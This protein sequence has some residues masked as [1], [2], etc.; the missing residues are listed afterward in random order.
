MSGCR[1]FILIL[2]LTLFL[3]FSAHAQQRADNVE[4]RTQGGGYSSFKVNGISWDD[5][6]TVIYR[7]SG[8]LFFPSITVR[9][10]GGHE[11]RGVMIQENN[12]FVVLYED[13]TSDAEKQKALPQRL[14]TIHYIKTAEIE[15]ISANGT[16]K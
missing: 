11:Y 10:Q 16:A 6:L 14:F 9:T 4:Q 2:I 15:A 3:P 7:S 1:L 13:K 8:H 12:S 5:V